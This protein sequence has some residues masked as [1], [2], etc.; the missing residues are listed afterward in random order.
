MWQPHSLGARVRDLIAELQPNAVSFQGPVATNGVRWVGSE[1]G[2]TASDT[3]STATSPVDFGAGEPDGAIWAPAECDV[4]LQAN[5]AWYWQQ[6]SPLR[7]V[8]QLARIYDNCVGHNG[9]LLL[10]VSVCTVYVCGRES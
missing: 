6:G 2:T 9:N 10:A 8:A 4:T 3:W 5:G 1:A 7:T